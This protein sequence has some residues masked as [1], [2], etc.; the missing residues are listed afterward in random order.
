LDTAGTLVLEICSKGTGSFCA[1]SQQH[2]VAIICDLGV[3][4]LNNSTL[5][6]L[7]SFPLND[8]IENQVA[9]GALVSFVDL[10]LKILEFSAL[11][12]WFF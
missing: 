2:H 3:S 11:V 1:D 5:I 6:L 12:C 9:E 10:I 8:V 7:F 4:S